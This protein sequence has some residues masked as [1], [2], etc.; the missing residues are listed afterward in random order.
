MSIQ[1]TSLGRLLEEARCILEQGSNTDSG[2]I[3]SGSTANNSSH[4]QYCCAT[5]ANVQ[6]I[7]SP[8]GLYFTARVRRV[9]V[10]AKGR[11]QFLS[12]KQSDAPRALSGIR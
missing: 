6:P 9:V 8:D 2:M 1:V 4:V 5:L 12:M 7:G 10:T 11:Y 3:I